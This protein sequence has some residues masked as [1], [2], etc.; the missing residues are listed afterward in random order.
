MEATPVATFVAVTCTPGTS[1]PD[2]STAVPLNVA[3]MPSC[4]KP[5]VA[6]NSETSNAVAIRIDLMCLLRRRC[7]NC[8][9]WAQ[10]RQAG[11][12]VKAPGVKRG[13]SLLAGKR[14]NYGFW[15]KHP[16]TET[17]ATS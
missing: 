12:P 15:M 16:K 1:A 14:R 5:I 17:N 4:A 8:Y 9:I 7:W 13:G 3:L 6:N 11:G 2:G 10:L